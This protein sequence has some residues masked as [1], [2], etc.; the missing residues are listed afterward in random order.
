MS[1]KPRIPNIQKTN[2]LS[3]AKIGSL[4]LLG[5]GLLIFMGSS[6]SFFT[7]NEI[8]KD[9][10]D[11]FG[12]QRGTVVAINVDRTPGVRAVS[13]V[14]IEGTEYTFDLHPY[15]IRTQ[16]F[17]LKEQLA[18][19]RFVQHEPGVSRLLKGSLRGMK[20]SSI[21]GAMMDS[22]LAAKI[23]MGDGRTFYVE[24]MASRMSN[25][26]SDNLHVV[27]QGIDTKPH[28]RHCG[29][30]DLHR[31]DHMIRRLQQNQ[32]E[33]KDNDVPNL[34]P[35][36][37]GSLS[38][39]EVGVDADF[40]Y[41]SDYGSV[42]ATMD[43]MELVL[44]MVNQQ[45]NSEVGISHT[46]SGAVV[47]S[48]SNDPYTSSN[49][50]TLLGQFQNE[51]LNNQGG[52]QRDIAH[53]FTG[54]SINGGTIGIA[55][56]GAICDTQMGFGLAES[57]FNNN[58]G[59]AVDLSAHELGHNWDADHCNCNSHTM[60]P[61]ITCANT[62]NPTL[63]IPVITN[64]RD[65]I[66]CLRTGTGPTPPP[67][68]NWTDTIE[69][70]NPDFS[71]NGTN[72]NGTTQADEQQLD[73]TGSTVWWFFDADEDGSITIDT[74][75]SGYDTQLHIY[76]GFANGFANLTPVTNNDDIVQGT[77]QSQVTF[78]V[79]AGEC[80][81]IRV[82]G[83]RQ[84][85]QTGAG[86]EGNIVLNGTFTP[87]AVLVG[88]VNCDGVINL[89]DVDP[90]IAALNGGIFNAKADTNMDGVLNLLDVQPFIALLSGN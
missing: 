80:Y 83:Y 10:A 50:E 70:A 74:L 5:F 88:D 68:D 57:D 7:S 46:I 49:A 75:G 84:T 21:V 39:C 31:G 19:G 15:S 90:F 71:V 18:D 79:T 1:R 17:V 24:P 51:W 25:L 59:C 65:S 76:T 28:D 77:L 27:Y 30:N 43:R 11:A 73:N 34:G 63:T 6:T 78:D 48:N 55:Y 89:L 69:I 64:F 12:L 33:D 20:G 26:D 85:G 47:R 45:Y 22:G 82:G 66:G 81:E 14:T 9:V 3:H 32:N 60:N 67:N 86:A 8:S 72:V 29:V 56:L 87:D 44:S 37:G 38:I 52:I 35:Q 13:S 58:L 62:F 2:Q 42:Q 61:S 53:L 4:A 16:H 41:F 40:E 23:E 54:K 36:E